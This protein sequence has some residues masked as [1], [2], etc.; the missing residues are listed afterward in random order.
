LSESHQ[1]QHRHKAFEIRLP[2]DGAL[3]LYMDGCL[4]KRREVGER[5][6]QYVWT[7]VEL[8][9]EE[10]HYIEARFWAQ[11]RRLRVTV[12]GDSL[13]DEVLAPAAG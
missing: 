9:W 7:N 2:D 11:S 13:F 4:R 8:E 6:P 12:N 3:E 10:H 1:F 5:E